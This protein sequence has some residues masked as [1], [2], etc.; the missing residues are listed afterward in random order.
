MFGT[1]ANEVLLAADQ[2]GNLEA[3]LV[4]GINAAQAAAK[5]ADEYGQPDGVE[6]HEKLLVWSW[7]QGD[8]QLAIFHNQVDPALSNIIL[9]RYSRSP[10]GR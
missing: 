4:V 8:V 6:V 10:N 3:V 7:T 9:N 2:S 5:A 1:L